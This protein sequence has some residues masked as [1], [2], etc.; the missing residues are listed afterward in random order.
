MTLTGCGQTTAGSNSTGGTTSN[1]K[2]YSAR[3]ED[4][5]V[6]EDAA[7]A[8][9]DEKTAMEVSSIEAFENKGEY[10]MTIRVVA[11]GGYYMPDVAE[12]TAQA[13]FDKAQELGLNATQYVVTEYSESSTGA[14]E[15][16]LAWSSDDGVTGIYS[17]DSGAEPVVKIG[18][19]LNALRELV[20]NIK[21]PKNSEEIIALSADY[22]GEW[23]RVGHEKYER[24]VVNENTVNTVLFETSKDWRKEKTVTHIFTLYFGLDEEKGL[25]VTNQYKQV[26]QT[27]S[28]N[29]QGEIELYDKSRDETETYRKVSDSTAVPTV[30]QVLAD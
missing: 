7:K 20:G 11:A 9:L 19:S 24:L 2:S 10:S 15:N 1:E 5:Q 6:L 4:T 18:V 17:D 22:Q 3:Q 13:F 14:K 8:A 30:G 28:M 21:E 26:I 27:V 12:Q 16:M 23:E 29:E 25:V